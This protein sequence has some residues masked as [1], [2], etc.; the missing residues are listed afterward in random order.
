MIVQSTQNRFGGFCYKSI[1]SKTI[2]KVH[3]DN[4]PTPL[5]FASHQMNAIN[6]VVASVNFFSLFEITMD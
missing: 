5:T 3:V 2:Q 4:P 6:A 1:L